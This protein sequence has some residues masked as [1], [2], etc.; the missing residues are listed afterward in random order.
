MSHPKLAAI[1][2]SL[3]RR[4]PELKEELRVVERVEAFTR[5]AF[6]GKKRLSGKDYHE[7]HNLSVAQIVAL[8]MGLGVAEVCVA[9]LHDVLEETQCTRDDIV[10]LFEGS[11]LDGE[12]IA[13]M[14]FGLS[15]I[16][17]WED[18]ITFISD[19]EYIKKL[20]DAVSED[21]RTM[22]IKIAD[23]VHN[24]RDVRTL[25]RYRQKRFA[26]NN[27]EIWVWLCIR[28]GMG[29]YFR[30]LARLSLWAL[31]PKGFARIQRQIASIYTK[32]L[33]KI[34]EIK[35]DIE[36]AL[37]GAGLDK[38]HV[39]PQMRHV[40]SWLLKQ[41]SLH[42]LAGVH[43][44]KFSDL[45]DFEVI[46]DSED[47]LDCYKCLGVLH[48]LFRAV[49]AGFQDYISE[50]KYNL[51]SALH[52]KVVRK[53][54]TLNIRI[55]TAEMKAIGEEGLLFFLSKEERPSPRFEIY[56]ELLKALR[57]E[58]EIDSF[59]G[60]LRD[61]LVPEDVVVITPKRD[62]VYLPPSSSVIDFAFQ[63]HTDLGLRLA[64]CT[65]NGETASIFS[66]LKSGDRVEVFTAESPVAKLF[67]KDH[68]RT[69][70]AR[71]A[72]HAYYNKVYSQLAV[73]AGQGILRH[74]LPDAATMIDEALLKGLR[75][76]THEEL[77]EKIARGDLTVS[78]VISGIHRPVSK[79]PYRA[80]PINLLK[81]II[82]YREGKARIGIAPGEVAIQFMECCRPAVGKD[83]AI[84]YLE[85]N[86][87]VIH[88]ARCKSVD[89]RRLERAFVVVWDLEEEHCARLNVWAENRPGIIASI[90]T[91][92]FEKNVNIRKI[93]SRES[94]GLPQITFELDVPALD[95]HLIEHLKSLSGVVS[96]TSDSI[97]H[98]PKLL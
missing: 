49:P 60:H 86:K 44:R 96:V 5:E 23:V 39:I 2:D 83:P 14:V 3:A 71:L 74:A 61:F 8:E 87:V 63:I 81:W 98:K 94:K 9:L 75:V 32:N 70:K 24:T 18:E 88:E 25:P 21:L 56:Q 28:F 93:Y 35:R 68:V 46:L 26:V 85:D 43:F 66:K 73:R 47:P 37:R 11:D 58:K 12:E 19:T 20:I 4:H 34:E 79:A 97:S 15:K 50:R 40:H 1:T 10:G 17:S 7:D 91:L 80:I 36:K 92:L 69:P 90:A 64:S 41:R 33:H 51:Y 62:L 65:I 55:Q 59:M 53:E 52:T 82:G 48:R 77:Y 13:R 76:K 72:L 84:G 89:S 6:G 27:L 42:D 16:D 57:D 54:D 31:D 29:R 45:V 95:R 38:L 67:W 30:E 78:E 22:V